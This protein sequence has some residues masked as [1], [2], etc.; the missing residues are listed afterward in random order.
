MRT[1][2]ITPAGRFTLLNTC[3]RHDVLLRETDAGVAIKDL[4]RRHGC[5]EASGYL[6]R[7]K[8]G[9]M[10]VADA[11]RLKELENENTRL[12][13]LL[14]ESLL[15]NEARGASP[16]ATLRERIVALAHRHRRYGA[17]MIHLKLRQAGERANHKRVHRLYVAER[18]Q[19]R[20][21]AT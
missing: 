8:F 6:W 17:G 9:G 2:R 14:A 10:S 12:Q 19:I 18:L 21:R 16:N 20:R 11:K 13:K 3:G 4:C 15:E 5:S 1:V 7:S